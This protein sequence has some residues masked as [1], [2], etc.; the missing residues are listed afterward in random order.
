MDATPEEPF[1]CD[2]FINEYIPADDKF[3]RATVE[4][5][6]RKSWCAAMDYLKGVFNTLRL[7][8]MAKIDQMNAA[9]AQIAE[10]NS[11]RMIEATQGD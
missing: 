10:Q 3:D 11:P 1:P 4:E 5:L 9:A 6:M 8:D 2:K 7:R